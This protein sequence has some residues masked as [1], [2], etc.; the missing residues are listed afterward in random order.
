MI[1]TAGKDWHYLRVLL[2]LAGSVFIFPCIAYGSSNA[3]TDIQRLSSPDGRL[4]FTVVSDERGRVYYEV[5][6]DGA[7]LVERSRLGFLLDKGYQP[8]GLSV[9]SVDRSQGDETWETVWGKQAE[10]RDHYRQMRL[11]FLH[12]ETK[13]SL[14]GLQVRSYNDGVAFRY[15]LADEPAGNGPV[16]VSG[17][18]TEFNFTTDH[19]TYSTAGEYA[20]EPFRLSVFGEEDGIYGTSPMIVDGSSVYMAIHEADLRNYA[21]LELE[22]APM[23]RFGVKA[24]ISPSRIVDGFVFPW[25]VIAIA[26]TPGELLLS[27]I[28]LNLNPPSVIEDTSWIRTGTGFCENRWW[29]AKLEDGFR[30]GKNHRSFERVI[31][32]ASI[33]NID[34]FV[35]DSGWYG[36]QFDEDAD[37]LTGRPGHIETGAADFY[38]G[39]SR[40]IDALRGAIDMPALIKYASQRGVSVM[41]YI[42]DLIRRA[43]GMEYLNHVFASYRQWGAAGIKY[44]F[45]EEDDPQKKVIVTRELVAL[46]AKHKLL[47][48][49]HDQPIHPTGERRTYPNLVATEFTHAQFDARRTFMPNEFLRLVFVNMYAGPLDMQHGFYSFESDYLNERFQAKA[50]L[51]STVAGETARTLITFSGLT[52]LS[53]HD[54]A[55]NAKADL[56]EFIAGQPAN[57][58][59]TRILNSSIGRLITTARRSGDEWF[60]ASAVDEHG[61]TVELTLDFLAP[62]TSYT[63]TF[64]EDAADA[65][66]IDNQEAYQIRRGN[67]QQGDTVKVIMA[68]GGGHAI[69]LRPRHKST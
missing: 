52:I 25:R 5:L 19:V 39:D 20:P 69:W 2:L 14:F 49:F 9:G 61:G 57:W 67:V 46:A 63:A 16:M 18:L 27:T 10:I 36:H 55:Y 58:D 51:Y 45:L 22:R 41:L 44:G 38:S 31:D 4:L 3:L 15:H 43:K 8:E 6:R 30:Y 1:N 13:E 24:D 48:I 47:I 64:Y 11:T 7:V 59:E 37:P 68:P 66:Y 42:N 21:S 29:G 33:N 26:D 35:V 62:A 32:F 40:E 56:F 17:E 53:D 12:G 50:K 28:M 65:H 23:T 34:Y 54:A 60:V